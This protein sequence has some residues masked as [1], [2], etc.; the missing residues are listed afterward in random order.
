[1]SPSNQ[2]T[3][4]IFAAKLIK[5]IHARLNELEGYI[6]KNEKGALHKLKTIERF[7]EWLKQIDQR[8]EVIPVNNLARLNNLLISLKG[9]ILTI[10]ELDLLEDIVYGHEKFLSEV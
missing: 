5:M 9:E 3:R 1:M 6:E 8:V 2:K 4:N 7:R 10:D